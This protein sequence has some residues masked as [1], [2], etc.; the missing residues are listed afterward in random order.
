[1]GRRADGRSVVHEHRF[2]YNDRGYPVKQ[3]VYRQLSE[4][5]TPISPWVG[6]K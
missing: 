3:N 4:N 1:M 5:G 2:D 6:G